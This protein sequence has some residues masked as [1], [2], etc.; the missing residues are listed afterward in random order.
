MT[1]VV[2]NAH[3]QEQVPGQTKPGQGTFTEQPDLEEV[4]ID[5]RIKHPMTRE[6]DE[7]MKAVNAQ[8]KSAVLSDRAINNKRVRKNWHEIVV[9]FGYSVQGEFLNPQVKRSH[10][11]EVANKIVGIIAH[12]PPGPSLPDKVGPAEI[13]Y[14]LLTDFFDYV[15]SD[16]QDKPSSRPRSDRGTTGGTVTARLVK[17]KQKAE[18]PAAAASNPA[19]KQSP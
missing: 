11:W 17:V 8:I 2:Q 6:I 12:L 4:P 18:Q 13:Q 14:T 5:V 7:C 3:A 15:P 19:E 1:L 9:T 10:D 16:D